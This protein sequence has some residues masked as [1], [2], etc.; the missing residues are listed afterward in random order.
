LAQSYGVNLF[1][2][3]SCIYPISAL[4][5]F[6]AKIKQIFELNFCEAT[7]QVE[8]NLSVKTMETSI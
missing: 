5:I 3:L 6:V 8:T 7:Y 1:Y 2:D 4:M